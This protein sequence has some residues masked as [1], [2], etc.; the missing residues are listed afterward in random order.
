MKMTSSDALARLKNLNL[1]GS[2][3]AENPPAEGAPK[4]ED[5]SRAGEARVGET[6][7][8]TRKR[9]PTQ[10]SRRDGA[11]GNQTPRKSHSKGSSAAVV[12]GYLDPVHVEVLL[13]LRDRYGTKSLSIPSAN[14][15]LKVALRLVKE[16]KPSDAQ[17]LAAFEAER[18][19]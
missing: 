18:G 19:E 10:K 12:T 8:T 7:Q 15:L 6:P 14:R 11:P 9:R 3:P 4:P 5:P 17:V 13:D 2:G 16:L 1:A